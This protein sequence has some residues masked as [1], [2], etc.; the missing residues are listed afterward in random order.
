MINKLYLGVG[1]VILVAIGGFFVYST[2]NNTIVLDNAEE[3]PLI[4]NWTG[5]KGLWM[6]TYN[7]TKEKVENRTGEKVELLFRSNESIICSVWRIIKNQTNGIELIEGDIIGKT[8][9]G[10]WKRVPFFFDGR[11]VIPVIILIFSIFV[12]GILW[13][14]SYKEKAKN[15]QK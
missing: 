14:F 3:E 7:A 2:F 6:D 9:F 5:T 4:K 10:E 1:L 8:E 12:L 13:Y 15:E 11:N